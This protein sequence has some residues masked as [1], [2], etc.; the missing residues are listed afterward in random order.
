MF[1]SDEVNDKDTLEARFKR[2]KASIGNTPKSYA[3]CAFLNPKIPSS[4]RRA[5]KAKMINHRNSRRGK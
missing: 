1:N 4:R 3:V 5:L 2:C